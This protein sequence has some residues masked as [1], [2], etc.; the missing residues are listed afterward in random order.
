[1]KMPF[2]AHSGK[3]ITE[4][5]SDYLRWLSDQ[6]FVREP[7]SNAVDQELSR[8][9]G[10][11]IIRARFE[12]STPV[13]TKQTSKKNDGW[14]PKYFKEQ[15]V[16]SRELEILRSHKDFVKK[17]LAAGRECLESNGQLDSEGSRVA[18]SVARV[19]GLEQIPI[20]TEY[21]QEI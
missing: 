15:Y 12:E 17:L 8:R 10:R 18:L 2:G 9:D 16:F 5:P 21:N 13:H 20:D 6:E 19:L 4:V 11:V 1:M 7:L 14:D 3:D